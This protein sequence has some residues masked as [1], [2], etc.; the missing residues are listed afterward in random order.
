MIVFLGGCYMNKAEEMYEGNEAVID[1]MIKEY[2]AEGK[3]YGSPNY[4]C[5]K[6]IDCLEK[7]KRRINE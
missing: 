7:L 2:K 4:R 6:E 3:L 5:Q 1:D